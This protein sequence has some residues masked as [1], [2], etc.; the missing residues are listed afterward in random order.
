MDS[1]ICTENNHAPFKDQIDDETVMF[2]LDMSTNQSGNSLSA[3]PSRRESRLKSE[4]ASRSASFSGLADNVHLE[5]IYEYDW[6]DS[7][8]ESPGGKHEKE[9]YIVQEILADYLKV[10]YLFFILHI[11]YSI[12][13]SCLE[14]H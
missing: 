4:T 9:S 1:P 2:D 5:D 8:S 6:A 12:P 14:T 11:S 13:F 7:D 3:L 10:G